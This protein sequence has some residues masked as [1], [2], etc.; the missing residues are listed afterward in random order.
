MVDEFAMRDRMQ[1]AAEAENLQKNES[2]TGA[3]AEIEA[4]YLDAWRR[5]AL[6]SVELRERAHVAVTLLDD[7]RNAILS[8]V[9]DGEVA[10]ES[11]KKS[12]RQSI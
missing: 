9:R 1:R 12:L 7:I 6:D 10:R 3:L 11:L 2:F 4:F 8:R 5:S